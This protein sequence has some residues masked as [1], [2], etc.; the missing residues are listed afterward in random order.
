ME[1]V[2][3]GSR[4]FCRRFIKKKK[5]QMYFIET[6][7]S[8]YVYRAATSTINWEKVIPENTSLSNTSLHFF[9]QTVAEGK[10]QQKAN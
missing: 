10:A 1:L 3:S 6:V 8:I 9:L 5:S 4:A 2:V 7:Y